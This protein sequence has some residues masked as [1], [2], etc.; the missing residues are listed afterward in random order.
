MD[1]TIY[2]A[3]R[4]M[5]RETIP[6]G[7]ILLPANHLAPRNYVDNP[8]PFRQDSH[9]LYY[10]GISHPGLALLLEDDGRE[11]VYGPPED[12]DDLVWF[13]PQPSLE[14]HAATAGVGEVASLDALKQRLTSLETA[15]G[16][17]HY[18]PPYRDERRMLLAEFLGA[19][20]RTIDA[21]VSDELVRA[22]IDQRNVKSDEEVAEIE[23]ALAV[24]AEMYRA[25]MAATKPGRTEAEIAAALQ[26]PAHANGR[27]LAFP[28][29]VTVR[30]EVLHNHFY[31]NTLSEGDLMVID[32]GS[33]SPAFYASDITRSW[34]VSGTFSPEQRAVYEIVLTTQLAAIDLASPE[35]SNREV[36][37]CAARTIIEG[38]IEIGLMQ[39][40]VEDALAEGA[41]ALFYPHGIGHMLGL[42]VHD[43]EDLGD[44]V[45]YPGGEPRS[46]QFGLSLLRMVRKLEPGF[47][48]TIEPGIYFIPA[49]IERWRSED[50]HSAFI[51]Y[52]RLDA[53]I[54]FGGI[55]IEDDVLITDTGSRVL[56]PGIPKMVEEIE[57]AV[58]TE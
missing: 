32:S 50:R 11:V 24:T 13:G 42:D 34:P 5:L 16:R 21:G 39:G 31:G 28:P 36:H 17:V 53:F 7:A 58:G 56:G 52:D 44:E 19:D 43:M 26:R 55:R 46:E 38:L 18:L 8:Y 48:I 35:T 15:D 47:V 9:F 27:E 40:E 45:G 25:A 29:I 37:L 2:R 33:E 12:P 41:H 22:V 1:A 4:Q 30:G 10:T 51:R 54:G 14:D 6:G 23:D 57:A 3:R 49:L 20:P